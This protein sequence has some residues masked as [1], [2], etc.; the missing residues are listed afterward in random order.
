MM[1]EFELVQEIV[2]HLLEKLEH[3]HC[4]QVEAVYLR[5]GNG[6]SEKAVRQAYKS[7]A[8]GT[9]LERAHIHLEAETI[10]HA[11]VCGKQYTITSDDLYEH[12][13]VCPYCGMMHEVPQSNSLEL[14]EVD[15][16]ELESM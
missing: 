7:L 11:C 13:F 10:H 4:G 14:L 3:V 6:I 1:R 8:A 5:H 9:G 2:E 12:L 15:V 16:A